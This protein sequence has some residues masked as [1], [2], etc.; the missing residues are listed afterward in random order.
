VSGNVLVQQLNALKVE[1]A[2][3]AGINWSHS[4][5]VSLLYVPPAGVRSAEHRGA[6]KAVESFPHGR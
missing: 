1:A 3:E 6:K 5:V 2:E 4:I